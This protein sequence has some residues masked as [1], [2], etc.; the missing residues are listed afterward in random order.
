VLL[1]FMII[2]VITGVLIW[3]GEWHQRCTLDV[4]AYLPN[5]PAADVAMAQAL[6]ATR[7]LGGGAA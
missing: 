2:F 6:N 3:Q 4:R 7:W 1:F 5:A